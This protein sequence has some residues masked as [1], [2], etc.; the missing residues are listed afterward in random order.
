METWIN[1]SIAVYVVGLIGCYIYVGWEKGVGNTKDDDYAWPLLWPVF[2]A[3]FALVIVIG[4]PM[5][6]VIYGSKFIFDRLILLGALL[7][8]LYHSK[9]EEKIGYS[10]MK[11][12]DW[13]WQK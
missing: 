6:I 2:V 3:F 9:S 5:F 10:K 1:I 12:Q 11:K 13:I 8:K 7:H 4:L